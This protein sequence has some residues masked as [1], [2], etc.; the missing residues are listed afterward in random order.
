MLIVAVG[1]IVSI[2]WLVMFDTA[3]FGHSA[4]S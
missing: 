4:A 1:L 2:C 3:D